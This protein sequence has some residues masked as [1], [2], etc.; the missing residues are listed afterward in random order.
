MFCIQEGKRK[1]LDNLIFWRACTL[2][3][4]VYCMLFVH[5]IVFS[6]IFCIS[7]S[8]NQGYLAVYDNIKVACIFNLYVCTYL[9]DSCVM[10][11]VELLRRS[12]QKLD[13]QGSNQVAYFVLILKTLI[14]GIYLLCI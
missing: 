7:W 8:C 12:T 6:Y 10:N 5:I 2:N 13:D 4:I 14:L 9:Y 11:A 1:H 3:N